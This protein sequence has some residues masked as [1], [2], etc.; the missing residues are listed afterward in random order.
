MKL[1]DFNFDLPSERIARF[2]SEKRDESRLMVVDRKTGKISHHVFSDICSLLDKSDFLVM[3][4][5]KVIPARIFGDTGTGGVEI[6]LVKELE[7]NVAKVFAMPAKK[8][9]VGKTINFHR[10]IK[11]IVMEIGEKGQ[12]TLKFNCEIAKVL[13]IGFAPL[14]PYI[15]RKKDEAAKYKEF[16]LKRY[17]TMFSKTPGS[18]AAP[19]AGLHFSKE[20][21]EK[22]SKDYKILEITLEVGPATFQKIET[23][24]IR[25]HRMGKEFIHIDRDVSKKIKDLKDSGKRLVAVGTTSVRSL[26]TFALLSKTEE[27]FKSELFIF[28]GFE[29]KMVE[30]MITNFHLPKSSLFILVSAFAGLDIMKRAYKIAI[31]EKYRFFSY[32]D[33][34]LIL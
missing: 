9:N 4:N 15:K 30:R 3:N 21:L 27:S 14:P 5:T 26:E 22:L 32:G 12:R 13:E 18:I 10:G 33:A 29:F 34:M 31:K 20:L 16:D 25:D 11:A 8:L 2:P 19:T 28:P 23:E 17:Q 24:N 1:N 6:L 7:K